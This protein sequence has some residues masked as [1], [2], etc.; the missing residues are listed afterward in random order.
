MSRRVVCLIA[1]A[2]M[3]AAATAGAEWRTSANVGFASEYVFRGVSQSDEEPALQGGFDFEHDAGLYAGLWGSSVDFN[4]GDEASIEA[5][6]YAGYAA[7]W[8]GLGYDVGAIY[9][10]YPGASSRLDYDFFEV[11]G[12]LSYELKPV[13]LSGGVFLSPEFFGDT[14]N[15][16]YYFAAVEWPLLERI[17]LT[18]HIGRQNIDD[19]DS[20]TDW[21]LAVAAEYAGFS[22]ELAYHD[23]NLDDSKLADE[24][25]VLAVS[26]RF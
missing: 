16:E 1:A 4:D 11:Y 20:Y 18:A 22:A 23:T 10:A 14:G 13:T 3:M 12:K 6:L 19:A 17:S 9:Y 15:A 7:E 8:R 2:A 24:R 25:V 26:R 5:D 21:K